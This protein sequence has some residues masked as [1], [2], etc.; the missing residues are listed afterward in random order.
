MGRPGFDPWVGKI[1]WRR[2]W[3]PTPVLFYSYEFLTPIHTKLNTHK[4]P[5]RNIHDMYTHMG[6]KIFWISWVSHG[7]HLFCR[8]NH[9]SNTHTHTHTHTSFSNMSYTSESHSV[10]SDSLWPHGLY[11]R[12]GS[13]VHGILQ[14]RIL[15]WVAVSSSSVLY[16]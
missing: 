7:S 16:K 4:C 11:S 10:T 5:F 15:E 9:Q 8:C 1:P 13:S 2:K 3:Q 12:L 6:V 14:A